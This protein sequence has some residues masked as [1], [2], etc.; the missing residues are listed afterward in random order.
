LPSDPFHTEFVRSRLKGVILLQEL[1]GIVST[2]YDA[3]TA[4]GKKTVS[5]ELGKNN[6]LFH[7]GSIHSYDF[8]DWQGGYYTH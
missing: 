2:A 6:M 4:D 3:V 5:F 8:V 1:L 7:L